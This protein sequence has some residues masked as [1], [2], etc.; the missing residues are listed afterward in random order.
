MLEHKVSMTMF[1]LV[2][3]VGLRVYSVCDPV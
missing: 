1:D 2:R 3:V